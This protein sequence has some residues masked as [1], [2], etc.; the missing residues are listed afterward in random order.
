MRTMEHHGVGVYLPEDPACCG[1]PALSC[2]D[3]SAFDQ[4]V[5]HNLRRLAAVPCDLLVTACATCTATIKVLWPLLAESLS[6]EARERVTAIA[7]RTMDVSQFLVDEV[8]VRPA[9]GQGDA[10]KVSVT[11]HDPCHLKKSLGVASQPRVLLQANPRYRLV[12]MV[13]ADH[14][15][16]MGGSF[17]LQHYEISASIGKRKRDNIVQSKCGVVATS[18]PAC[19]LQM[20]DMLSQAGVRVQVRHAI[21][22]YAES[23]T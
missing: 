15:C 5:R 19:M 13:E 17:N 23:F 21:E 16:G 10:E 8:G 6:P 20:S 12:E 22:I 3:T 14:C 4:L 9:E 11:Y 18:C 7:A 2:G 1:I